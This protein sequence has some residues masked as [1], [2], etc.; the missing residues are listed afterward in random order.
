ML[1]EINCP[2]EDRFLR[3]IALLDEDDL[4]SKEWIDKFIKDKDKIDRLIISDFFSWKKTNNEI[5]IYCGFGYCDVEIPKIYNC[6]FDAE[7]LEK[8]IDLQATVKFVIL[9]GLIPTRAIEHGHRTI[10]IISFKNGIPSELNQLPNW[11]DLQE[12]NYKYD[13][14]GLCDKNDFE[15]IKKGIKATKKS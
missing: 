10:C 13:K 12:D 3:L 9:N 8:P 15:L 4:P 5:I 6:L 11:N 1:Q 2:K 14:L 7:S